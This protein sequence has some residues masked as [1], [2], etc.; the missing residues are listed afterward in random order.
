MT[1]RPLPRLPPVCG[2]SPP[3]HCPEDRELA[4]RLR[5]NIVRRIGT[6]RKKHLRL[7]VGAPADALINSN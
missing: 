4:A 7:R 1:P 3:C 5:S 6:L 2:R